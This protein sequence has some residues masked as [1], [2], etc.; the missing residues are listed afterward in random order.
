MTELVSYNWSRAGPNKDMIQC[1][2]RQ[3]SC[4]RATCECDKLFAERLLFVKNSF[5]RKHHLFWSRGTSEGQ[6]DVERRCKPAGDSDSTTNRTCCRD[7][8]GPAVL[9]NDAKQE[10]CK[11]FSVK[12]IGTC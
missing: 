8:N 3:N 2:N 10:C 11:D 7:P 6:F 1:S 5:K 9:F 4:Q 12:P